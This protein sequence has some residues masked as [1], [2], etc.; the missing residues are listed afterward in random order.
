L[1]S[2][3]NGGS[4]KAQA[5]DNRSQSKR[6]AA[7]IV[8]RYLNVLRMIVQRL[9]GRAIDWAVTGSCGFALQGLDVAVHDIDLQT[10]AAGA[11]AIERAL[12]DKSRRKVAHST[13]ERIRSH[14]GALEIDGVTV[15]IMGDIQK[16]LGDGTWE[17]PVDIRSHRRWVAIDGMRIPVLSLEYEYTAYLALGRAERA[18]MLRTWLQE[19][20]HADNRSRSE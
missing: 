12:A 6:C 7:M 4:D 2:R 1:V 3:G 9:E 20:R 5:V 13:G 16:R 19:H 10:D 11:Y 8:T 17:A 15:E 14:F 18:E